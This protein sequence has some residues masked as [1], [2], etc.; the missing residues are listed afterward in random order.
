MLWCANT[1]RACH[2]CTH[3]NAAHTDPFLWKH[4]LLFISISR[5]RPGLH[6]ELPYLPICVGALFGCISSSQLL[7]WAEFIRG[8]VG[9]DV[10]GWCLSH[11][12]NHGLDKATCFKFILTHAR[13]QQTK[14]TQ[15]YLKV[16][17]CLL[18]VASVSLHSLSRVI[19][20]SV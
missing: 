12:G 16:V 15:T 8:S 17:N 20:L 2:T 7:F 11:L 13:V 1:Q 4:T 6:D 9:I 5:H 10:V 3:R 18:I 14:H 19:S